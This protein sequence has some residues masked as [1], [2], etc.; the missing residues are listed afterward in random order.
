MVIVFYIVVLVASAVALLGVAVTSFATTSVVDRVLAA[1]FAVCAAGNAWHLIATGATRGVVFVPAF[2]VPF[3][4]GYKLYQGFRHREK[5][6]AD[7]DAAKRALVAAEEWRA[8][9]RW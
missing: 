7:R 6:R 3:Y 2:F 9:R 1:F 4:A 8:S 5:R